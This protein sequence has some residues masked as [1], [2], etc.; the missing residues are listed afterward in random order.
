MSYVQIVTAVL[1]ALAASSR[2][3]PCDPLVFLNADPSMNDVAIIIW[4]DKIKYGDTVYRVLN[5]NTEQIHGCFDS[6][7]L[8]FGTP[9]HL[10]IGR[11]WKID[12]FDFV[13][14][15]VEP[16]NCE[17]LGRCRF[18]IESKQRHEGIVTRFLYSEA[19]GLSRV[20]FVDQENGK[21]VESYQAAG[22]KRG[23][24]ACFAVSP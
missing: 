24:T 9:S 23:G 7:V 21:L 13:V 6:P 3:S 1:I 19:A 15:A 17:K 20:E 12:S 8:T 16:S 10:I 11:R 14:K 2:V 22:R 5:C 18:V 4:S